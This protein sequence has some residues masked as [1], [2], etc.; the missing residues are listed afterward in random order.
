MAKQK[1]KQLDLFT[2]D[3]NIP[4][5]N[6]NE[7]VKEFIE[8]KKPF[9]KPLKP[10]SGD[11]FIY[12]KDTNP[13]I[14][15]TFLT[16]NVLPYP[17]GT[18]PSLITLSKQHPHDVVIKQLELVLETETI[19]GLDF[20][21]S[22]KTKIPTIIGIATPRVAISTKWDKVLVRSI[23][24][25][26]KRKGIFS[27]H[28]VLGADKEVL[29]QQLGFETS[30]DSWDDSMIRHYLC[31]SSLTKSPGKVESE[32]AL[33]FMNLVNDTNL[34]LGLPMWKNCRGN[35]CTGPCPRCLRGE[36]L[37]YCV[38]GKPRRINWIVKHRWAGDVWSFDEKTNILVPKK[39]NAWH[40][41]PRNGRK[42]YRLNYKFALRNQKGTVLTGDHKVLTDLG[43]KEVRQLDS[44]YDTINTGTLRCSN[45]GESFICGIFLGDT[46]IRKGSLSITHCE[47]QKDYLEY[48]RNL[49]K[50]CDGRVDLKSTTGKNHQNCYTWISKTTPY[51]KKL[52]F[53]FKTCWRTFV[54]SYLTTKGLAIWY[55]DDG[56]YH[57]YQMVISVASYTY[58]E[59]ELLSAL[60]YRNT[61]FKCKVVNKLLVFGSDEAQKL[62][63]EISVL[64]PPSLRYKLHPNA[65]NKEFNPDYYNDS[66]TCFYS[67]PI[68][69]EDSGR[70]NWRTKKE[71]D[72]TVYCIGVEDTENFL[73]QAGI[74]HNCEV[75]QYCAVDAYAGLMI[76][77]KAKARMKNI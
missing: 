19:L 59:R 3:P 47:D 69:S 72:S 61:G 54:E 11:R 33:G 41:S 25:F 6:K 10:L 57:R 23:K 52:E 7:L 20:E 1:Q 71:E 58:E 22:P 15:K 42:F 62:S 2:S 13:R 65:N 66:P 5:V 68:I 70:I 4:S 49:F 76:S 38:D 39:I 64:V 30:I 26:L 53:E 73:T 32:G 14:Q 8:K 46:H 55:L 56:S 9:T 35:Y 21:F 67:H 16:Q 77:L 45:Y 63:Q 51:F 28:L 60:I 75:F 34:W 17:E 36:S 24:E 50:W 40:A 37:V 31:F 44:N 12:Y 18:F 29:D 43:Y 48:K 27:G 74:V